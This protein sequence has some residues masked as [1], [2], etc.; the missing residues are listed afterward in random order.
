[1]HDDAVRRD[2]LILE[3]HARLSGEPIERLVERGGAVGVEPD[4]DRAIAQRAHVREPHAVRRQHPCEGMNHDPGDPQRIRHEAC[5]L[6][7]RSA[8]AVQ[9]VAGHVVAAPHRDRLDGV[10]HVVDRDSEESFRDLLGRRPPAG[11]RSDLV[12][13]R[14]ELHRH[15]VPVERLV[16]VRPEHP[17]EELGL[18]LAEEHVAVG[19][20]QRATPSVAR[21]A[22]VRPGRLR[23]HP[24][25][26]AVE[27]ANRAASRRHGVDHHHRGTHAHARHHG[28]ESTLVGAVVVG[29]VGRGPAHVERDDAPVS[30]VRRGLRCSHDA[31]GGSR[32]DGVLALE[33]P[34]VGKAAV[35]LHEHETHVRAELVR[36][37]VDVAAQQ[38]REVRIRHRGVAPADELH[39]RACPE[40][41]GHL[42][43]SDLQ[44]EATEIE[45]VLGVP[46]AVHEHDGDRPNSTL[47]RFTQG[48]FG[49]GHVER[50]QYVA[51]RSH[52]TVHFRN[53]LIEHL[54]QRN[55]KV[56]QVRPGLV[57]DAKRV[58]EPTVDHQQGPVA[59]AL[60]GGRW[61]RRWCPS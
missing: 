45:L 22:G 34:G 39:Q 3:L 51:V 37:P 46:V 15:H 23:S 20:A 40:A 41:G 31:A 30:S 21:R 8:E 26:G 1:M 57:A 53:P 52:P 35:R 58:A 49:P 48:R 59:L 32:Q 11:P 60:E 42:L 29:D 4:L 27:R 16:L 9:G 43:E 5:V 44:G 47:V 38:G 61:W 54:G 10:R 50:S 7:A 14:R 6:A 13:Q 25:A 33:Q 24:V 18:E 56:E 2:A 12:G 28:L 55:P 36:H 17:R 19:H